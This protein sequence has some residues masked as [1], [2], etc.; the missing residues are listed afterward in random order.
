MYG[1]DKVN[2]TMTVDEV[3][4]VLSKVS[5][6]KNIDPAKRKLLAF[7]SHK[8][9]FSPGQNLLRQGE[10]G[11]T[12]YIILAGEAEVIFESNDGEVQIAKLGVHELIGEIAILI[13]TPRTATVRALTELSAL[14]ISKDL[15]LQWVNSFPEIGIE[16]MRELAHRLV[17]TTEQLGDSRFS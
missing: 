17:R 1:V 3:S 8:V 10:I 11:D 14:E 16:V 9:R 5:L 7:T 6:F 15:F 2:E 12:A 13:D 4:V